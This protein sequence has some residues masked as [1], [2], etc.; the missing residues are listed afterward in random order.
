MGWVWLLL[1]PGIVCA[2]AMVGDA[3]HVE[4]APPIQV[5]DLAQRQGS[6]AEGGVSV[7]LA[8]QVLACGPHGVSLALAGSAPPC[9]VV[10]RWSQT[11]ERSPRSEIVRR[12]TGQEQCTP[13]PAPAAVV[14]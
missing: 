7:K 6:V 10:S 4:S 8:E 13:T 14:A 1:E 11:G 12:A 9:Q 3:E 2:H 5:D